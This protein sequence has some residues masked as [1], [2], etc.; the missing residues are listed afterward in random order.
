MQKSL[1]HPLPSV[2]IFSKELV[3]PTRF[4]RGYRTSPRLFSPTC[5]F[6]FLVP[7]AMCFLSVV[8]LPQRQNLFFCSRLNVPRQLFFPF[9]QVQEPPLNPRKKNH[10]MSPI[11][12]PCNRSNN[13]PEKQNC[14]AG[15]PADGLLVANLPTFSHPP[16]NWMPFFP[17]VTIL[18]FIRAEGV[19]GP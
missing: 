12:V 4:F 11:F 18:P 17:F 1:L 5:V 19:N 13:L 2:L 14:S 7:I 8:L 10:R 3:P 6:S 9:P 15:F 16:S